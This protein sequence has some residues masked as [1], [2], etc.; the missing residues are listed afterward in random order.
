[1]V[2]KD[3]HELVLDHDDP[4]HEDVFLVG[5]YSIGYVRDFVKDK[6]LD[7]GIG[8]MATFNTNPSSLVPYYGGTK[9]AGW[10]L[11]VRFRPS[12]MTH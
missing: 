6:G 3:G 10:Q 9:H 2:Q 4:I 8:G 7:M 1:M 5:A 11:F 12:K